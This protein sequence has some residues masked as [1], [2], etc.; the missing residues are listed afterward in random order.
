MGKQRYRLRSGFDEE[1]CVLE[2]NE[3][4]GVGQV[5]GMNYVGLA[6]LKGDGTEATDDCGKDAK[7]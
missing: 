7:A 5:F 3:Q 1:A 2:S 6:V 4:L